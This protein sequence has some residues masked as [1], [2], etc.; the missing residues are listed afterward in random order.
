MPLPDRGGESEDAP[1]VLR[2]V[3]CRGSD[4]TEITGKD[5][6]AWIEYMTLRA[7][8]RETEAGADEDLALQCVPVHVTCHMCCSTGH[9]GWNPSARLPCGLGR[10]RPKSSSKELAH[11][12]MDGSAVSVGPHVGLVVVSSL[13]TTPA[14][15]P[16]I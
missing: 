12:V 3:D 14:A 13:R 2:G 8:G 6:E 16:R 7:T 11:E 1:V 15:S 10:S 4:G 9:A 5:P